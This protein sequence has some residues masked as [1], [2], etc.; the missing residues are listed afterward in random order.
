MKTDTIQHERHE[1]RRGAWDLIY[2]EDGWELENQHSFI[3]YPLPG[4][5]RASSLVEARRAARKKVREM[6]GIS[7]SA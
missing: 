4:I 5:T 1:I 3:C 2:T 6:E 7:S